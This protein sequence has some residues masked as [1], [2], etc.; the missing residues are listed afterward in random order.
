VRSV[1]VAVDV[2]ADPAAGVVDR[3]VLVRP[4]LRFL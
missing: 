3:L 2:A 1:V 4:H